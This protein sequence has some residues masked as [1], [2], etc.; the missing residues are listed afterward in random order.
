MTLVEVAR[1]D[2]PLVLGLP[3]TGTWLPAEV[4]DALNPR[5]RALADTDWH[6]HRLYADLIPDLTTVRTLVHR[7]AIDANRDPAGT[8][9]YPGQNTTGLCPLT[10]FDGREVY[11]ADRAPDAVEIAR[12][13]EAWHAELT[14]S[15]VP[16]ASVPATMLLTAALI[17]ATTRRRADASASALGAD[18]C[19]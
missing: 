11:R 15:P 3:H 9:L 13:R 16:A 14:P 2:S 12:R 8:S 5:G 6:I 17:A 10:D 18:A 1:G 19:G 7:Y 4:S